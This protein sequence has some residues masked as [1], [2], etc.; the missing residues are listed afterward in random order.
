MS[1]EEP[2]SARACDKTLESALRYIVNRH[3]VQISKCAQQTKK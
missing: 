1:T 3:D 2:A